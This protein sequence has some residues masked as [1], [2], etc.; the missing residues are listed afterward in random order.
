[1]KRRVIAVLISLILGF[2]AAVLVAWGCAQ[3][4]PGT[5]TEQKMRDSDLSV[6]RAQMRLGWPTEPYLRSKASAFGYTYEAMSGRTDFPVNASAS[7]SSGAPTA[8]LKGIFKGWRVGWPMPCL[9]RHAWLAFGRNVPSDYV[10]SPG[11]EE[12]GLMILPENGLLSK[13]RQRRLP[14]APIWTGLIFNTVFFAA[15]LWLLVRG[16][17]WVRR[18]FRIKRG[19]CPACGYPAGTSNACTECGRKLPGGVVA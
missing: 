1:M 10:F 7:S 5:L 4:T 8:W 18:Y 19:L 9:E 2:F 15:I 12:R 6:W 16:P 13:L 11:L 17:F 3:L 14:I